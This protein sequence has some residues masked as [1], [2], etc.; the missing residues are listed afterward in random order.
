[1]LRN[2]VLESLTRMKQIELDWARRSR[3]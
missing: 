3:R 2:L 1:H